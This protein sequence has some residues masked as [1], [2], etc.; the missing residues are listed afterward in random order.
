MGF[1]Y[2]SSNNFL[3][4]IDVST[5]PLFQASWSGRRLLGI[6]IPR[7]DPPRFLPHSCNWLWACLAPQLSPLTL[8]FGR[9]V[10]PRFLFLFGSC[11]LPTSIWFWSRTYAS[12]RVS[13]LIVHIFKSMLRQLCTE[14]PSMPFRQSMQP[15]RPWH[16]PVKVYLDEIDYLKIKGS[17]A[18]MI[19]QYFLLSGYTRLTHNLLRPKSYE[20]ISYTLTRG[21]IG[22]SLEQ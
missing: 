18:L 8:L 3:F 16:S 13:D 7:S 4:R 2:A 19:S 9:C 20:L 6:G 12:S 22:K 1:G 5:P 17:I 14:E 11:P 15:A 21:N 10:R